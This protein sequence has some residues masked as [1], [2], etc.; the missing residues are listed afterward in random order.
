[1][2]YQVQHLRLYLNKRAATGQFATRSVQP[3]I[4]KNQNLGH[5]LEQHVTFLKANG[6]FQD[7]FW[8]WAESD[9]PGDMRQGII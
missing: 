5:A 2:S 3:E 9:R 8:T 4:L 7:A 6:H 1:M